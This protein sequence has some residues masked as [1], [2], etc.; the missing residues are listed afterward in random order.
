MT[1]GREG[2]RARG[3]EQNLAVE[4][5]RRHATLTEKVHAGGIDPEKIVVLE[6]RLG[7]RVVLVT[8]HDEPVER[9][10]IALARGEQF[11][12]EHLKERFVRDRRDRERA[13]GSVV[14]EPG[15]LPARDGKG[16]H[17]AGAQR[18]FAR[19][20]GLLPSR[21]V[22]VVRHQRLVG[23]RRQAR[24]IHPRC[25]TAAGDQTAVK[26]LD[27]SEVNLSGLGQQAGLGVWRKP[28]EERKHLGL[29]GAFILGDERMGGG[30]A[31][32]VKF[33]ALQF[34]KRKTYS[35]GRA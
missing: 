20:L 7:R 19:D 10:T 5:H 16:R 12:S 33:R 30:H 2:E 14:A 8:G 25:R 15:P 4:A 31:E 24:E 11:F 29:A 18:R 17:A 27:L 1:V 22:A 26:A 34:S 23:R 3:F 28:V 35:S 6:K 9:L 13:L 21:R 32:I